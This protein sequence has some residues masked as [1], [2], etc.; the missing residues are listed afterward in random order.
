MQ[1]VV[2]LRAHHLLKRQEEEE[3]LDR[4]AVGSVAFY[5]ALSR[6]KDDHVDGSTE[7]KF[8][9]FDALSN[10]CIRARELW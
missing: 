4:K 8:S 2:E 3:L 7:V 5:V 10:I 1:S 6:V 9:L